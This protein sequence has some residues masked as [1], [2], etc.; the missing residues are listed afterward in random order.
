MGGL[1]AQEVIGV[2]E[3]GRRASSHERA[4]LLAELTGLDRQLASELA[5]GTRDA[6][7]AE[8]R[9]AMFG[10]VARAA[11]TCP[12]CSEALEFSVDFAAV[13]EFGHTRPGDGPWS[14]RHDSFEVEFRLP[15][16]ADLLAVAEQREDGG[17]RTLLI[18]RIVVRAERNGDAVL[19]RVLPETVIAAV[20]GEM[21]RL[22]PISDIRFAQSC[23]AC[24]HRF[25]APFD[26]ARFC[27]HELDV[28]A[29]RPL[30]E[31]DLLARLYGWSEG[32]I[33]RMSRV[34]RMTYL[35]MCGLT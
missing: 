16:T 1:D 10:E 34:R 15:S 14:I 33:L 32:E 5:I 27:W 13:R 2:W 28:D 18:E 21:E 8:Q 26:V 9:I 20:E 7:L 29:R 11:V 30:Q 25:E 3:R 24:Q 4:L 22:D 35:E 19:A 31:V 23:P 6:A 12:A 17:G